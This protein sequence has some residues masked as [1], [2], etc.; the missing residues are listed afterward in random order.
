V[1]LQNEDRHSSKSAEP[2]HA[3]VPEGHAEVTVREMTFYVPGALGIHKLV[4]VVY[5]PYEDGQEIAYLMGLHR[6]DY[7]LVDGEPIIVFAFS[8]SLES[9]LPGFG[10]KPI[11][12]WPPVVEGRKWRY[13]QDLRA[14]EVEGMEAHRLELKL[15][16]HKATRAEAASRPPAR[17]F[18][19]EARAR[20]QEDQRL[21]EQDPRYLARQLQERV[22]KLEE[23]TG[24]NQRN[25]HNGHA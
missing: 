9:L 15:M 23:L 11:D 6:E 4:Q 13:A 16:G 1:I 5:I 20:E 19:G 8:H 18:V 7:P 14:R 10:T 17:D 25:G 2:I 22:R 24:A 21:M 3:G 12:L